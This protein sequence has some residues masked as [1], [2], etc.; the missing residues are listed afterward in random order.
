[1]KHI[2]KYYKN[3][4]VIK[5]ELVKTKTEALQKKKKYLQ[6]FHITQRVKEKRQATISKA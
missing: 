3:N 2:V 1:M 4:E 5:V 6:S